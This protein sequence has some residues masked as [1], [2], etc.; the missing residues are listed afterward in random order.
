MAVVHRGSVW[1]SELRGEGNVSGGSGCVSCIGGE[2]GA[3][4]CV[5]LGF[6]SGG[7]VFVVHRGSVWYSEL[8][9]DRN[10]SG[11]SMGVVYRR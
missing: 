7:S 6:V 10:V 1:Y 5:G 8:C 11:G 9:G 2:Y 4:S 3:V